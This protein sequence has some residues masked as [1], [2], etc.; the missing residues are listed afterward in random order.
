MKFFKHAFQMYKNDWKRVVKSPMAILMALAL[1]ILPCF[2]AWFNIKALWDPYGNTSTLPVAVYSADKSAEVDV[3]GKKLDIDIGSEVVA[4]LK[5]NHDIGWKF[6]DSKEELVDGVKS[7][8][9]YAGI[10]MP[11]DFSS[12]LLSFIDDGKIKKPEIE[13]Y[14]NQKINAIA[15]KITEK[16]AGS[17]QETIT[18]EFIGTVSKTLLTSA[19]KLGVDLNSHMMDL[20]KVKDTILYTNNHLDEIESMLN[21]VVELKDNFPTV[22]NKIE[23]ASNAANEAIPQLNNFATKVEQ[24]NQ[25]MPIITQKLSPILTVQQKIPEIKNAGKQIQMVDDNFGKIENTM[26]GAVNDAKQGIEIITKA[27]EALPEVKQTLNS[28]E[29]FI[30]NANQSAE[31][32]QKALPQVAQSVNTSLSLVQSLSAQMVTVSNQMANFVKQNELSASDKAAIQKLASSLNGNLQ[33]LNGMMSSAQIL[34][35]QLDQL[36]GNDALSNP[37]NTLSQAKNVSNRMQSHISILSQDINDLSTRQIMQALSTVNQLGRQVNQLTRSINVSSVSSSIN[38]LINQLRQTLSGANNV[39]NQAQKLDVSSL[40]KNTKKTLEQVLEFLVV[41][42]KQMPAIKQEV[43]D[44]NQLLNGNMSTITGAINKGAT[45][46][47]QS[48]PMISSKLNEASNFMQQ[49]LPG[50]ETE[51]QQTISKVNDKLPAIENALDVT[52]SL[53]QSE[54]PQLKSGIQKVA[55]KLENGQNKVDVKDFIKLLNMNAK[56]ESNFIK[57]P[58]KVDDHDMYPIPTYGSAS[59]P[60]YT[61][62][63]LWVGGL[64]S[65]SLLSTDPYFGSL[66]RKKEEQDLKKRLKQRKQ[67]RVERMKEKETV[68]SEDEDA[69]SWREAY[70]GKLMI[71]LSFAIVQAIAVTLGNFFI[72]EVYAVNKW[73]YL[74]F[75][76]IVAFTFMSIIYT[77]VGLFKDVGKAMGVIVL[78]LSISGGGGNFPI[79]LSGPFFQFIYPFLPFTYA[80]NLIREATGGIYWSNAAYDMTILLLFAIAFL[81]IGIVLCPFLEKPMKKIEESVEETHFFS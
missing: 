31:K 65:V 15:P 22:K 39:V 74:L 60:F 23:T 71:F 1:I 3:I 36:V 45:F 77:F 48:L 26:Q 16:G 59:A 32:V 13:Y 66:R 11:S 29:G 25:Q 19:N 34:M 56:K 55:K 30:Q 35:K 68:E 49:N 69:I 37:I 8:K 47:S 53:I 41:F 2:Y 58:V 10:Y 67:T 80:V 75:T 43:H 62:L 6:V 4:N 14:V 70:V 57:A 28:A 76:M 20:T 42:Q 78:V 5:K 9:Y 73:W 46:Y 12:H 52:D 61:V 38:R 64:L 81:A 7:G 21:Q 27:Q 33:T 40:L 17:I 24:L 50:I 79:Q 54:W 18:D 44:A 51:V 63:C 72:L